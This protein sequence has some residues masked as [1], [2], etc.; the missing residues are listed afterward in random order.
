[1]NKYYV[2]VVDT[3]YVEVEAETKEKAIAMI[4]NAYNADN[5]FNTDIV[6]YIE[7]NYTATIVEE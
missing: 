1:M 2:C 6:E 5:V 4:D 3:H 7:G